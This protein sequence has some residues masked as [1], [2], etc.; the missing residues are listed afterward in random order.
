MV[1]GTRGTAMKCIEV[2][3]SC[4][5]G[6][7]S[8]SL[9]GLLGMTVEAEEGRGINVS[10]NGVVEAMPDTVELTATVEGNAELAGDAI[11]KYRANKRRVIESVNGLNI[12]GV[13]IVG[14]G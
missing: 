4:L 12:N 10:G 1:N 7:L 3:R 13:S 5:L 8:V 6:L 2:I 11:E 14:A 9:V